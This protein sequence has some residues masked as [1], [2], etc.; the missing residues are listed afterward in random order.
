MRRKKD[1]PL[2]EKVKKTAKPLKT[3]DRFV[4]TLP[5]DK[6]KKP[7][8]PVKPETTPPVS[9]NLPRPVAA[10]PAFTFNAA[11]PPQLLDETTGRKIA[12]GRMS[13]DARLDLH[14]MTQ[15]QAHFRLYQFLVTAQQ[16]G[17]RTILV[18]T[19]K[20][21]LGEG[22]LRSQV[23]RWLGEPEFKHLVSGYRESHPNHG[24]S[25]A[26]YIRV[27]KK[28]RGKHGGRS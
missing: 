2:W 26:L 17:N 4:F 10:E 18:I 11:P 6:P 13:I 24:G 9:R 20:G 14:G 7:A 19:G 21:K 23:P 1:D 5:E 25:G 27:R 12:K 3:S 28:D 15:A 8:S 22:I 16:L